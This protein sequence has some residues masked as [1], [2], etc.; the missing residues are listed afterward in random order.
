MPAPE[1]VMEEWPGSATFIGVRTH[2]TREGKPQ[3]ETRY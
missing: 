1:W 2:G 3:D